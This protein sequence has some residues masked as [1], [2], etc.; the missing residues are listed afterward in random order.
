MKID[1]KPNSQ[2]I[3]NQPYHLNP[4]VKEKV[5]KEIDKI[6]EA[7]LIFP[8]DGVEWINPIIIQNKKDIDDIRVYVDYISLNFSRIY[9]PFPTHLSDEV[10][11]QV[12]GKEDYCFTVGLSRYHQVCIAKE[13]RN[14]TTFT[15]KWGSYAYN[16]MPFNLNN[17]LT[18]FSQ[19]VI[20]A[21]HDFIHKY[22]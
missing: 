8:A 12:A 9:D 16:V 18:L 4:R 10:L 7:G 2:P 20:V 21:F 5:K 1:L 14:N 13:D 15:T 22:L 3:Q 17:A 6:L 11:E 19:I